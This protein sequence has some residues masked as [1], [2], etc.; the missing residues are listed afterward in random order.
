VKIA[1]FQPSKA[2]IIIRKERHM[3]S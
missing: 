2:H 3:N 1:D